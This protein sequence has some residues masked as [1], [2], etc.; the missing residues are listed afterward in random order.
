MEYKMI[1]VKCNLCGADDYKVKYEPWVTDIDLKNYLSASGG[2]MGVN[3]IVKCNQCGLVYVNPQLQADSVIDAYSN[4]TDELYVSQAKGREITFKKCLNLVEKHAPQKGK[5]LDI[6]CAAGFFIKVAKENG[7]NIHGVEVSKWLAEY[8][9]KELGL[10]IFAG[11]L[12]EAKYQ[13]SMF[14]VITMWDVLEH[15]PD[16]TTVLA[17]VNRILKKDGVLFINWPDEGS[18]LT[19]LAGKKWWFY[20]S[21]HMYYFTDKTLADMLKK[22]GFQPFKSGLHFQILALSHL[23][24]MVGLYNKFI[25]NISLK[26]VNAFGMSNLNIPYYAAQSYMIARKN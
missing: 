16:P 6:G 14:D 3:R 12:A 25:S 2:I 22:A 19:K 24:K 13:D 7:W 5:I 18:V 9:K 17:E 20:L 11:T 21:N 8:G 15:T 26:F 1:S 10:N 23:I 4:S